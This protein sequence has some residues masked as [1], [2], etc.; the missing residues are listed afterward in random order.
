MRLVGASPA[1]RLL[2]EAENPTVGLGWDHSIGRGVVDRR[3]HDCGLGPPF[4]MPVDHRRE[5]NIG[6]HIAV[7]GEEGVAP[8]PESCAFLSAPAVPSG[9]RSCAPSRSSLVRAARPNRASKASAKYEVRRTTSLNSVTL[10]EVEDVLDVGNVGDR[11][12]MFGPAVGERSQ[13]SAQPAR[14]D[15][16]LQEPVVPLKE[17]PTMAM[18]TATTTTPSQRRA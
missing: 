10:K 15:E 7:E 17:R 9:S 13:A 4:A 5:I 3:E 6:E 14:E 2:D 1:R 12:Q 11:Q 16:R 18:P 8:P